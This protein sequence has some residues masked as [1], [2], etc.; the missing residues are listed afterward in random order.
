MTNNLEV[1]DNLLHKE[2]YRML[3]ILR[4]VRIVTKGLWRL[5]VGKQ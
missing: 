3:N 5:R 2:D 1:T 4:V